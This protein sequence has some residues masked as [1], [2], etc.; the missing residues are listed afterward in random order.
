MDAARS[1]SVAVM[2]I[3][4]LGNFEAPYSSENHHARTLESL[5]HDVVRIPEGEFGARISAQARTADLFVWVHSHGWP[6]TK[7][8]PINYVLHQLQAREIPCVTYHLDLYFGIPERFR[9]YEKHP[10]MTELDHFFTCDPPLVEYLNSNPDI[11]TMG[12]YLTAGVLKD[13]CYLADPLIKRYPIIFVGSYNYHRAWP[14]RRQLID[15]LKETYPDRFAGFGPN[16]GRV[17]R[18]HDLN[19]LYA[20]SKVVVGDSYSP[21]FSYAG[22]WSDRIPETLGRGGFLIHPRIGGIDE[23]YTDR[24]HLVLYDYGDFNQL[25]E[26]I[27]YYLEHD[28]ERE[29]IRVAGHA[30][31][32][33][34][35]TFTNRWQQILRTVQ[36]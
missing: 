27:N 29:K 13:E 24:E 25:D 11:K 10:Y 2:Q 5:G 22:Y 33:A 3:A 32:K 8:V 31:V 28:D 20:S 6:P 36:R 26:L 16:F 9:D 4:F 18:G 15:W 34:N 17:M 7:G 30:H 21:G 35:H 14:Y 12:H 19:Q 1:E 23:F